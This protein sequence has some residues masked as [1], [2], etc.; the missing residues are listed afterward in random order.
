MATS[1]PNQQCAVQCHLCEDSK[2]EWKCINCYIKLCSKCKGK[3]DSKCKLQMDH[4]MVDIN[5]V[6]LEFKGIV[7]PRLNQEPKIKVELTNIK[8]YQTKCDCIK[9][10][11]ESLNNLLWIGDGEIQIE[12]TFRQRMFAKPTALQKIELL[13]KLEKNMKVT[14]EFDFKV[15]DIA[16]TSTNDLLLATGKSKLK[17]ISDLDQVCKDSAYNAETL[18]IQCV[19]V[20]EDGRV[21]VGG[22]HCCS[23]VIKSI[24]IMNKDGKKLTTY[25][26]DKKNEII[27]KNPKRITSTSNGN[28]F[29]LDTCETSAENP[30]RRVVVIRKT[31]FIIT[32]VKMNLSDTLVTT[33]SNH[34]I[35]VETNSNSLHFLNQNGGFLTT[36]NTTIKDIISPISLAFSEEGKF[37]WLYIGCETPERKSN[38]AMLYKMNILD[39]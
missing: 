36:V 32:F 9:L 33:S 17:Q 12:K 10:L 28:I 25:E 5:E 6:R 38:K 39:Y 30:E 24:Q 18:R 37:N 22:D 20:A 7:K 1:I 19:H 34:V 8:T 11:S 26:F 13:E 35:V 15:F 2:V 21:I 16:L 14:K 4:K 31:D 23:D 29:V 27:F 3:I